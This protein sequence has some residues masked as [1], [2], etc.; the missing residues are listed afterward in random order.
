MILYTIWILVD[1]TPSR[2]GYR[3]VKSWFRKLSMH[4]ISAQYYP[5]KLVRTSELPTDKNYVL[6]YH[7]HGIIGIGAQYNFGSDATGFDDLFPGIDLTLMTL[8][9][10]FKVPFFREWVMAHGISSVGESTCNRILSDSNGG[11]AIMIVV[12]GAAE[13][14][15][16]RPECMDL[17]LKRRKGFVR[18]ALRHGACLVPVISF[19]ENEIFGSIPNERGSAVRRW[20]TWIQKKIGVAPVVFFGRGVFNYAFG[21]LPYRRPI[22]SIV[23]SPIQCPHV[24]DVKRGDPIVDKWHAKYLD[25]IQKLFEEHKD[26]CGY[27]TSQM[28]FY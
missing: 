23:G 4:K 9:L 7:P 8:T 18:V 19:G 21:V 14:L 13:A 22:T 17:T 20:Q 24:P 2:G 16:A 12:G 6:G 5:C 1:R 26:D 28:S 15:D 3:W 10:T 11:R 25:S 27:G